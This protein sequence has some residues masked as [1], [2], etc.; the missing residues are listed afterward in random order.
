[1][2]SLPANSSKM[3]KSDKKTGLG[4]SLLFGGGK[5]DEEVVTPTNTQALE[6]TETADAPSPIPAKRRELRDR[7][8]LY[9]NPEVNERL[10]LVSRIERKERSVV[11]TEILRSHL[12]NYRIDLQP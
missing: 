9:L 12:P 4:R 8:T 1:M 10:D 3:N 6:M 2:R 5:Q 11:V 7:C